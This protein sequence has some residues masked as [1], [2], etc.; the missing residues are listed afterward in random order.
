MLNRLRL[1]SILFISVF[2]S[3]NIF[4]LAAAEANV[5]GRWTCIYDLYGSGSYP[6]DLQLVQTGGEIRGEQ[7]HVGTTTA[8][9][10]SINGTI[11]GGSIL[12]R[13]A[14]Y[15]SSYYAENV[16]T[17]N[18][19]TMTGTWSNSSQAGGF[20]CTLVSGV[21]VNVT[22]TP[23][24]IVGNKRPTAI[25]LFCNRGGVNL[26]RASCAV[27][28][29]DAGPP[30][31]FAPT[32]AV[33]FVSTN[34]FFP[35]NASCFPQQTQYSPGILSC[36]V[37]FQVP[38]G[39]PIGA[40]FPIDATYLGDT[41]FEGS[42][43]S[44]S[45]IQA[46]CVGTPDKPC[47]GAVA[48]SFANIPQ[49]LK[50]AISTVISC[51]SSN[52][53][54][55]YEPRDSSNIKDCQTTLQANQSLIDM[56]Q[57]LNA[58]QYRLAMQAIK[59]LPNDASAD[60]KLTFERMQALLQLNNERLNVLLTT[61]NELEKALEKGINSIKSIN[62]SSRASKGRFIKTLTLGTAS[63]FIKNN[64]QK[65]VSIK[66]SSFAKKV[67]KGMKAGGLEQVQTTFKIQSKRVGTQ[68][69]TKSSQVVGLYF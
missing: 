10:A 17:V 63:A 42:S 1:Y 52:T 13:H 60:E 47:S 8:P 24:P 3:F 51:G 49:I 34:G 30:P 50:N 43:T 57:Q 20:T 9:F 7:F 46:G 33:D 58:E 37:E 23:T 39:F 16:G 15:N 65:T 27:T 59:G 40:K 68:R 56:I 12:M 55:S 25:N 19:T 41:N 45:L 29:A 4:F 53:K 35:A 44:H 61:R 54:K 28:L 26:E 62:V 38:F 22:P 11:S 36:I 5:S 18:G 69:I 32:G 64:N 31:R 66:L 2:F 6:Q 48:M 21:G 67:L 14:Y